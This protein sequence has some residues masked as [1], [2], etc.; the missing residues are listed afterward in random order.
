MIS[1]SNVKS[2]DYYTKEYMR[3]D[4]YNK[5]GNQVEGIGQWNGKGCDRLGLKGEV[6][7]KQFW[8]YLDG[9]NPNNHNEK[10]SPYVRNDE[11]NKQPEANKAQDFVLNANKDFTILC[12]V[13]AD[14]PEMSKKLDEIWNKANETMRDEIE[15]RLTTREN[16]KFTPVEG[17]ISA[18]WQHR[19]ARE[20][21]GKIDPHKHSHNVYGHYQPSRDGTMKA[22]DFG[23]VFND[24]LLIG[25]KAQEVM[26][27]GVRDLGFEIEEA[28]TGWKLK[29]LSDE[30]RQDFSGRGEQIKKG[31]GENATYEEKQKEANKKQ[32]KGD[33]QLEDLKE[34]WKERLEKH[35]V[36]RD[37]LDTVRTLPKEPQKT[38]SKEDILRKACQISKSSTFTSKHID[39]AIAQK[40][41]VF[42]FD[43][44]KMKEEIFKDKSLVK[45]NQKSKDGQALYFSNA[46]TSKSYQNDMQKMGEANN[47]I[48]S[49]QIKN[50]IDMQKGGLEK[51]QK[52]KPPKGEKQEKEQEKSKDSKENTSS[53]QPQNEHK[54]PK[55]QQPEQQPQQQADSPNASS[56]RNGIGSANAVQSINELMGS[57]KSLEERLF[58]LK[59]ND[60]ERYVLQEKLNNLQGQLSKMI[61]ERNKE[62]VKRMIEETQQQKQLQKQLER[63]R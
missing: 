14:D 62:E 17:A 7:Q 28:K 8:N 63:T 41:Q 58:K 55:S 51:V 10:L 36:T 29:H 24:K 35:G 56:S 3:D 53:K 9:R 34:Q 31:I 52:A 12:E 1:N 54:E 26:A 22:V 59:P 57:I 39:I 19:T 13:Y 44:K 32:A 6:N 18:T 16:G 30:V 5:Q 21:D 25:S 37:T 33:Y 4:Y 11:A 45:T 47:R 23:R 46:I 49:A 27:K 38:I 2:K 48:K 43:Q 40:G 50:S 15:Q 20:Q 60:P 61:E 42:D